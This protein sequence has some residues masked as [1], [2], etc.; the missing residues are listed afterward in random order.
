[1]PPQHATAPSC[2]SVRLSTNEVVPKENRRVARAGG[3]VLLAEFPGDTG[4]I[5]RMDR[6]NR[7]WW[8]RIVFG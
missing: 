2:F 4:A 6:I 3:L 5:D 1:M 8:F 7:R